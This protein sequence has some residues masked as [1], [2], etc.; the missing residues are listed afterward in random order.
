[1]AVNAGNVRNMTKQL[2]TYPHDAPFWRR[3]ST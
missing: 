3:M 2:T 1:L